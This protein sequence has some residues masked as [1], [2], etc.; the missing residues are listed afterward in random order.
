MAVAGALFYW[1]GEKRRTKMLRK[2]VVLSVVM[3]M[4]LGLLGCG[5]PKGDL[6]P[7]SNLATAIWAAIGKPADAILPSDL[8]V[9]SSLD[10]A[11]GG[12]TDLTGLEYCTSLT[13]LDLHENKISDLSPLASLTNLTKLDLDYNDRISD[14]SPLANLTGLTSLGLN[15]SQI[16]DISPLVSLTNLTVLNLGENPLDTESTEVHIPQLEERGVE[17]QW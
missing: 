7:D 4:I 17:V 1:S 8:E 14:V 3:V 16:S 9:L 12:I 13:E 11:K 15:R 6:F 2:C 10:A 5:G